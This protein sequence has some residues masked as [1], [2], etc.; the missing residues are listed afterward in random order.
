MK[1]DAEVFIEK[2]I[3]HEQAEDILVSTLKGILDLLFF[4]CCSVDGCLRTHRRDVI[5]PFKSRKNKAC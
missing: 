2:V 1:K 4:C 5:T 3:K